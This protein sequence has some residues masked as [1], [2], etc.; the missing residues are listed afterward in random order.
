MF[1]LKVL[2]RLP[3]AVLYVISDVIFVITFYIIRYR[4][5]VVMENLRNSL[6][7][8]TEKNLR[9]IERKFFRNLCDYAAETLHLLTISKKELQRRVVFTNPDVIKEFTNKNHS[10]LVLAAHQFN[11]EWL[12]AAGCFNLPAPVDFVYQPQSSNL[13]NNFSLAIRT[14]FGGHPVKR[15]TVGREALR[16][17]S[18]IRAT[19]IVADQYPGHFNHRKYWATFLGQ[20][21][22][23]FHGI[24]QL[25]TLADAGAYF[26]AIKKTLR[27]HYEVTLIKLA[28]PPYTEESSLQIIDRYIEESEKVIHEQ[29]EGW[30]WSHKRWK[31]LD[32]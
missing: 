25:A 28:A 22:A 29:P 15:E 12:L 14:R 13:A 26:A 9:Q 21:T 20:Q 10:V 7:L 27:G 6:P 31:K 23:F 5:N 3:L 4:R 24:S 2:S 8:K 17:K 32:Y 16:R 18:I 1:V 30:L 19:A 11:W